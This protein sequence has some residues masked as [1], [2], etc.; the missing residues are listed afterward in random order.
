MLIGKNLRSVPMHIRGVILIL[1]AIVQ[2][3]EASRLAK[4]FQGTI[5]SN[6]QGTS[7]LGRLNSQASAQQRPGQP[8]NVYSG[9]GDCDSGQ[10]DK[11]PAGLKGKYFGK[12]YFWRKREDQKESASTELGSSGMLIIASIFLFAF[13]VKYFRG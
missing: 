9:N 11:K 7:T 5:S 6:L 12:G 10:P 4:W 1:L 13:M 2:A 8:A 3:C